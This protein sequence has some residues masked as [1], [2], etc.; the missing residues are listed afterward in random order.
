MS[1]NGAP[2]ETSQEEQ[3]ILKQQKELFD[4]LSQEKIQAEQ[5][6]EKDQEWSAKEGAQEKSDD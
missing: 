2:M 5:A 4:E 3:P 1:D 6:I